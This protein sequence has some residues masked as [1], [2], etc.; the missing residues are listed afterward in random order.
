[1]PRPLVCASMRATIV[2][3]LARE[4]R[5]LMPEMATKKHNPKLALNMGF[6]EALMRFAETD[7]TE[8]VRLVERSKAKKPP[9]AKKRT[10]GGSRASQKITALRDARRKRHNG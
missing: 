7:P 2:F 3:H 4:W 8:V 5:S 1:M 6:N 10:R 9:R